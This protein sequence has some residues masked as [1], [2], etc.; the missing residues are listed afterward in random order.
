[1]APLLLAGRY[2]LSAGDVGPCKPSRGDFCS[3]KKPDQLALARRAVRLRSLE[4][5]AEPYQAAAIV[6]FAQ[7]KRARL[8][9]FQLDGSSRK[10]LR[11]YF[12]FFLAVFFFA[13]AFFAF[14][15]MLPSNVPLLVQCKPNIDL[16]ECQ[17]TPH[18]KNSYAGLRTR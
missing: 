9:V 7:A 15:A 12:F 8:D 5:I 3:I 17:R 14:L 1:M 6:Y 13:F 11:D 2:R 18:L 4:Q 10:L 16:H